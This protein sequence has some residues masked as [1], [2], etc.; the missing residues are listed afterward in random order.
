[1]F[2]HSPR[3]TPH[4][5]H[6]GRQGMPTSISRT[7]YPFYGLCRKEPVTLEEWIEIVEYYR[8]RVS[9]FLKRTTLPTL[10]DV[11]CIRGSVCWL[12]EG[13]R[14]TLQPKDGEGAIEVSEV[15]SPSRYRLKTQ[16]IFATQKFEDVFDPLSEKPANDYSVFVWGLTRDNEWMAA[17]VKVGLNFGPFPQ[18]ELHK[19][20][21]VTI[22]SGINLLDLYTKYNFHP[23]LVL[24]GLMDFIT[25]AI[26]RRK[27]DISDLKALDR[28]M[29]TVRLMLLETNNEEV[30]KIF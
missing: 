14:G 21:A 10:G 20:T 6:H 18:Q 9:P 15:G 4:G 13:F 17:N 29:W 2:F 8:E 26:E 3:G 23:S 19:V 5:H 25:A 28:E 22:D 24:L 11:R 27:M 16:G 1:M 7:S 12:G 30:Q